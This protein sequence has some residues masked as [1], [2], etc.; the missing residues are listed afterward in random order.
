[1]PW[2]CS[3]RPTIAGRPRSATW[4]A[5]AI[6]IAAR[7][8]PAEIITCQKPENRQKPPSM[9]LAIVHS[10]SVFEICCRPVP[11]ID[12]R[13]RGEDSAPFLPVNVLVAVREA[14]A[15]RSPSGKVK[16]GAA[17]EDEDEIS[18]RGSA[19]AIGGEDWPSR[20]VPPRPPQEVGGCRA[21]GAIQILRI[22]LLSLVTHRPRGRTS[23]SR[24]FCRG[25][26]G[27][28]PFNR[29]FVA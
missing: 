22:A 7:A 16:A 23:A 29:T 19:G 27:S 24:F 28:S 14:G 1:M 25:Q 3:A 10:T 8:G 11:G 18:D 15:A 20:R 9:E 4:S 5:D 21:S 17:D 12:C 26:Y 2:K 13:T 6:P